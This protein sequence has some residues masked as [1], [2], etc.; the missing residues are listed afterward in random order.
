[1]YMPIDVADQ[2]HV[3][4]P[5]PWRQPVRPEPRVRQGRRPASASGT[6]S[7]SHHDLWDFDSPAAPILA[8]IT[9]DGRPIKAV[10]QLTKQAL[11]YVFDRV[12]GKPVWP[13]EERPVP[14]STTPGERTSPTQPFPTKPAPFDRQGSTTDD[15]IDF[16]PELRAEAIEIAQAL[17][18]RARVHSAV[19]QGDGPNDTK[20]TMQLPGSTGG[21]TGRARRSI[22]RPACSTFRRLRRRSSRISFLAIRRRR[23]CVTP[24][25]RETMDRRP[26]G[27]AAHETALRPDHG[28]RSQYRRHPGWCRMATAPA[29]IRR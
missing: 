21:R 22:R 3:R 7:S 14:Q 6:S 23:T 27:A 15:L 11:A 12:T 25:T 19:D 24:R 1:M 10:V 28:D 8:D 13:I 18:A 4:R 9:V 26:A 16:T 5:S 2:R 29:I 20:G 17:R